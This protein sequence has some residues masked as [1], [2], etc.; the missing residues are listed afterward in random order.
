[1]KAVVFNHF[2]YQPSGKEW[3][4][5][6]AEEQV[7]INTVKPYYKAYL[8]CQ[9][10]GL[11]YVYVD[12]G[13]RLILKRIFHGDKEIKLDIN[14][15][16]FEH[17]LRNI[18]KLAV[19]E[20]F[21]ELIE[22]DQTFDPHAM[23]KFQFIGLPHLASLIASLYHS[24]P[25]LVENL[26]GKH[27]TYDAPK[28]VEAV[29]RLAR[30]S[31]PLLSSDPILRFDADV[32]VNEMSISL[33]LKKVTKSLDHNFSFFSGGYGDINGPA[34]PINDHAVRCHWLVERN[35]INN[36]LASYR[37]IPKGA[38]FLR[39]IGEFGATL[40]P[41]S[42][43]ILPSS[44]MQ[45]YII[46]NGGK[47]SNRSSEQTI[48]GAGL[49]MS[50]SAIRVLPPFMNS[51]N[52]ITWVDDHLKRRLHEMLEHIAPNELEYVKG[53]LFKQNRHPDGIQPK[54][55]EW[56]K[57]VYF[58]R[59]LSG[60]VMHAFITDRAGEPGVLAKTVEELIQT[61]DPTLDTLQIKLELAQVA[62]DTATEILNIW[63]RADYGNTILNTWARNN[64]HELEQGQGMLI[65]WLNSIINDAVHYC[66]L[67]KKWNSYV[68]AIQRLDRRDA[69]WLF[70]Q[71]EK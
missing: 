70:R 68:N 15:L 7:I 30:G 3:L 66:E 10:I 65:E 45:E 9:N 64:H 63:S 35:E 56:A 42:Q 4:I 48:S 57:D 59:L 29:I 2:P 39:D 26:A 71:V 27:F 14:E 49:Y 47:S 16:A 28:F 41:D 60:C 58:Y 6:A 12:T 23:P 34:D 67:V 11:I 1:M 33:L 55:I 46:A 13:M 69:Y 61:D 62:K 53:S 20:S 50:F 54:D 44:E 18:L 32:E 43:N 52:N 21:S 40:T 51:E 31:N 37:L 5:G 22:N 17:T 8:K 36:N 38:Q 19:D 24:N 25:V